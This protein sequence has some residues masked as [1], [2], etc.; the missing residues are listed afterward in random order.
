MD[1]L[2]SKA[3]CKNSRHMKGETG[4][5]KRHLEIMGYRVVQVRYTSKVTVWVTMEMDVS[6]VNHDC[7]GQIS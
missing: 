3:F 5:R 6:E 1:F 4:M 2:D 7:N